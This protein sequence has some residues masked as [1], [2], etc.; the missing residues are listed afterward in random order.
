VADQ[1]VA[2]TSEGRRGLWDHRS[3]GIHLDV[4]FDQLDF[5]HQIPLNGRLEADR[6]TIPLA[7]LVLSKLQIVEINE[8]DVIDVI[9]LLLDHDLADSDDDAIDARRI[10]RM[11]AADWGLWRTSTRNLEKVQA[12]ASTYP[13]LDAPHREKVESQTA[14]LA[15][16]L[17][18]EPKSLQWRTRARIGERVKWWTDV[19]EVR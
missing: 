15:A 6:P 1:E 7:E 16:R 18:Q 17:D 5:C 10:A 3:N 14:A 19:D 4:F 9:L 2:I 12:L 11:C 8:K 13:Q